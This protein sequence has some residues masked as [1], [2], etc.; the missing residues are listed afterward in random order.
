MLNH[1]NVINVRY[2][3]GRKNK[4]TFKAT[5]FNH[6]NSKKKN[7]KQHINFQK[8]YVGKLHATSGSSEGGT[9]G[10]QKRANQASKALQMYRSSNKCNERNTDTIQLN[11]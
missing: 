2:W 10:T 3:P 6:Y 9:Q 8:A 1:A 11:S 4:S 5:L 7:N